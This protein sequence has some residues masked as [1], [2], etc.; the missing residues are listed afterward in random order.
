MEHHGIAVTSD[1]GGD[2][3]LLHLQWIG[4][5]S[6]YYARRAHKKG[7]PV[8]MSVHTPPDLISGSFTFSHPLALIYDR[9]LRAFAGAIDLFI[10]PSPF[11]AKGLAA[12]ANGRP[13]RVV[14]SGVETDR[15][16][17]D[18]EKRDLFR[19]KYGLD[20]P[21]VLCTGLLIPRKGVAEFFE[22]ARSLPNLSFVWVGARVNRSLFYSPRFD[23]LLRE[24]P[25]NVQLTGFID[26]VTMA[27][28]GCD[29]F[30]FPSHAESLGLVILEAGVTGL[31]LVVRRLPVYQGWLV[32]GENCLMGKTPADFRE[33]IAALLSDRPPSLSVAGLAEQH[34]LKRVGADLIAVYQEV[35]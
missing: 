30:F 21:T 15:F 7:R 32:G 11:A 2:Y 1:P 34:D 28:S 16:R 14:S 23:R 6:L 18:Q 13:I 9:Y 8:L 12:I 4:P 17:F 26:D 22:V 35:L 5:K 33:A 27:Y 25:K 3:D 24:H 29:L 19:R 31:P 10:A 20:R